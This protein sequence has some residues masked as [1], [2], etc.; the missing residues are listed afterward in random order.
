MTPRHLHLQQMSNL[1]WENL[2]DYVT[3][4]EK[5]YQ[6]HTS[7]K[8]WIRISVLAEEKGFADAHALA[9]MLKL[10]YREKLPPDIVSAI[11]GMLAFLN[12]DTEYSVSSDKKNSRRIFSFSQDASA[13]YSGF[14]SKYGIDLE[15]SDMHWYKFCALFENLADDNPFRTLIRIRTMD[16]TDVKNGKAAR[17]IRN[18]KA[19]YG[20]KNEKEIDVAEGLSC[21]F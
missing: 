12:G 4:S 16:E 17:H 20:L 15:K 10:C 8:N 9:Q 13:I 5:K 7:F 3:V 19:K 18:L 21:L 2:P 11:R 6:V 1:L 14:Y